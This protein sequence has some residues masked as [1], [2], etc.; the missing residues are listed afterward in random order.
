MLK[1][2]RAQIDVIK[3]DEIKRALAKL[4]LKDAGDNQQAEKIIE[5]LANRLTQ[6]FMH[7]PS[8]EIRRAGENNETKTLETLA[9]TFKLER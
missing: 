4:E 8:K 3:A 1:E 9:N 2:F 5:E 6:K 7:Q